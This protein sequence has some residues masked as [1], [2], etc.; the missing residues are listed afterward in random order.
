MTEPHDD[1]QDNHEVPAPDLRA[2]MVPASRA[3]DSGGR[4]LTR[5]ETARRLGMS[6]STLRRR[7]AEGALKPTVMHGRTAMYE[8]T[9]VSTIMQTVRK[10]WGAP[11]ATDGATAARVFELLGQDVGLR[12]VVQRLELAPEVVAKLGRQWAELG[13][14]F[15]VTAAEAREL[16]VACAQDV[17]DRLTGAHTSVE[18][19]MG[20]MQMV[21]PDCRVCKEA[22]SGVC[23]DCYQEMKQRAYGFALTGETL[24]LEQR[25]LPDGTEE[26]RLVVEQ[27]DVSNLKVRRSCGGQTLRTEW[28]NPAKVFCHWVRVFSDEFAGPFTPPLPH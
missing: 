22:G 6:E 20:R 2:E 16:G 21:S 23:V 15:F 26:V 10:R 17:R 9:R 24:R 11:E 4:L 12:E 5:G 28:E 19:A 25:V 7:E 8:E 14:G 13:E 1:S 18:S 27:C 3:T